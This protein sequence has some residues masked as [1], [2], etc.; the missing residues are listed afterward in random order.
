MLRGEMVSAWSMTSA[1]GER[2]L[3]IDRSNTSSPE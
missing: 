1:C 3:A 2:D